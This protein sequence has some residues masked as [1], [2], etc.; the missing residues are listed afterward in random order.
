MKTINIFILVL[1]T[2]LWTIGCKENRPSFEAP[3]LKNI[4][5]YSVSVTTKSK[6][7]QI[8]FNQGIIMANGFNHAEAERSFRES[9]RQD[10]TFAMGYWGIAYVLGPNVNSVDNMGAVIEIRNAVKNAVRLSGNSAAWEKALIKAIE[11]KFPNDTATNA[12]GFADFMKEAFTKFPDNAFVATLYAESVM[13]LHPW[14]FYTR[15]GGEPRPWT[16]EIVSLLEKVI[17]IDPENPLANHLYLHATEAS[18]DVEKALPSAERL[19]TLVPSAGHLVH[20][21]SHIYINTGDYHEGSIANEKAVMADSIYIAECQSQGYYPQLYY[22][23]NYHFLAATAAFEGRGARSIEAAYKTA[24]L[25]DKKYHHEV[26]YETVQHYLT[27]PYHVLVKFSQWEKILALPKPTDDLIYPTAIWHYSRGIANANLGKIENA[28]EELKLLNELIQSPRIA[29][30]YVWG[31]NKV[32]DVCILSSKVLKAELNV[33]AGNHKEAI[34]LLTDAIALEDDLN[35]NE[36]PDWFFSVRHILGNV[37]LKTGDYKAAEKLYTEDLTYWAKNGFAL[38]GLY[39]SLT[40]QGKTKEAEEVKKQF[41]Q[42]W[43]LADSE[44]KGSMIDPDKRKNLTLKIDKDS[45]NTLVY[46]ASSFCMG[47]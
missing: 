17:S 41:G 1:L 20:M 24:S 9:V 13:N 31:I 4:G 37:F 16:P 33:K 11:V 15:K 22:P 7:S 12:E 18:P 3:V 2:L 34:Q 28:N 21:P 40:G 43:N 29:E 19:K 38:S 32:T 14:D 27:I 45:P 39:E 46:L 10:S 26:G 47:N 5:N 23:H 30:Q 35:Y 8:F 36:P 25:I 44:L 42:A 6:Y